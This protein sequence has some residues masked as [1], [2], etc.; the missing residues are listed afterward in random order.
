MTSTKPQKIRF[1]VL[2]TARGLAPSRD[3][4]QRLIRAGEVRVNGQVQ[5]HADGPRYFFRKAS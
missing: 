2:M 4:A 1:D 3:W 5:L